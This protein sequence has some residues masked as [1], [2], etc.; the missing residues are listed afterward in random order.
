MVGFF[1]NLFS[2]RPSESEEER[3]SRI[4][5]EAFERARGVHKNLTELQQ[6]A[7]K[8]NAPD[9]L[10]TQAGLIYR[11]QQDIYKVF[12][13]NLAKPEPFL[14]SREGIAVYTQAFETVERLFHQ[15]HKFWTEQKN[16]ENAAGTA[17]GGMMTFACQ[18]WITTLFAPGSK[19]TPLQLCVQNNN[20][21]VASVPREKVVAE[22]YQHRNLFLQTGDYGFEEFHWPYVD[23]DRLLD[24]YREATKDGPLAQQFLPP[25]CSE[26]VMWRAGL[27]ANPWVPSL[28]SIEGPSLRPDLPSRLGARAQR[29]S[30]MAGTL[31]STR[32]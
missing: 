10:V 7:L 1:K 2:G 8:P 9:L 3:S 30:R 16:K 6:L 15:S 14:G 18:F 26:W 5:F 24:E 23:V 28:C 22:A 17:L 25:R 21:I 12:N 19:F 32:S 27:D 11:L 20:L 4:D 29:P 13:V 31:S